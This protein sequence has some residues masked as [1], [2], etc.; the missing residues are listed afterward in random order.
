MTTAG[1]LS[2]GFEKVSRLGKIIGVSPFARYARASVGVLPTPMSRFGCTTWICARRA[3]LNWSGFRKSIR[4]TS[5]KQAQP[6]GEP[7]SASHALVL[8]VSRGSRARR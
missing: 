7:L 2:N 4:L 3:D 6:S 5:M 8:C 1:I